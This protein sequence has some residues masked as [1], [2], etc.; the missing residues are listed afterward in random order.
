MYILRAYTCIHTATNRT[1]T[2]TCRCPP[3]PLA[4]S[5]TLCGGYTV[6]LHALHCTLSPPQQQD[7]H[8]VDDQEGVTSPKGSS[9]KVQLSRAEQGSQRQAVLSDTISCARMR[10]LPNKQ[11]A[12]HRKPPLSQNPVEKGSS[13]VNVTPTHLPRAAY[14]SESSGRQIQHH[15]KVQEHSGDQ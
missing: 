14:L 11:Q 10:P 2:Y 15:S 9:A 12:H 7:D 8:W 1:H 13:T 3:T 4:S 6:H 5:Q